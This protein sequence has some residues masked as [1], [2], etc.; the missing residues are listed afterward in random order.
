MSAAPATLKAPRIAPQGTAERLQGR[1]RLEVDAQRAAPDRGRQQA[2]REKE[3]RRNCEQNLAPSTEL[4]E[5]VDR[6]GRSGHPASLSPKASPRTLPVP[7]AGTRVFAIGCTATSGE[8]SG[9]CE[10]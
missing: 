2:Q 1:R 5:S 7:S 3:Q 10:D 4:E 8:S 6:R 9:T